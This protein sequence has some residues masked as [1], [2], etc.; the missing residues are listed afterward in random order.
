[1]LRFPNRIVSILLPS[2][3]Y[4]TGVDDILK[5]YWNQLNTVQ[6]SGPTYFAPVIKNLI[7][8]AKDFQDGKHYFVLLI[9]TD[10]LITDIVRTKQAVVK[11]SAMPISIIIGNLFHIY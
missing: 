6:L 11:A 3:P 10:G 1:M 9:I 2:D 4:C 8:I 5:Q 7:S